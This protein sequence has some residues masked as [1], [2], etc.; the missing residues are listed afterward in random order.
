[1]HVVRQ[2]VPAVLQAYKPQ[3]LEPPSTQAPAPLHRSA[4]NRVP[5]T[6]LVA[7]QT[8]DAE[9][10]PQAPEPLHEPLVPHE[11]APWSAHSVSGSVPTGML[12]QTPLVPEPVLA[13]E[14]AWQVPVH[15]TS[16]QNAS[17]QKPV[18]H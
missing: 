17:T 7:T 3:E 11:A 14:Q 10:R 5:F 15:A 16:Q 1:M 4:V 12:P 13:V 9:Y 8:V 18:V 6:Q 2:A